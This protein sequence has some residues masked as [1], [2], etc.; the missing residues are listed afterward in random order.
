M[1]HLITL[2]ILASILLILPG[3]ATKSSGPAG[4]IVD[5]GN[6]I[7]QDTKSGLMWTQARSHIIRD[8][9]VARQYAADLTLGGHDDWRLPTIFELY[10]INLNCDLAPANPCLSDREGNYWT[11]EKDGEGMVGAWEIGDH[12]GTERDYIGKKSGF[13]RAVRP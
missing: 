2:N 7:C 11:D 5:L 9:D 6:T 13:V 12:C 4:S 3:C 1:R 8:L 10:D